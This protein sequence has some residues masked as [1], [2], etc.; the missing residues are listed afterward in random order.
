VPTRL[1]RA[2]AATAVSIGLLFAAAP[3]LPAMAAGSQVT[4]S[5]SLNV[6]SAPDAASQIVG[7]LYRGQTVEAVSEAGGWT[8]IRYP[9]VS[10]AYVFT[11]YLGT[12]AGLPTAGEV[13][14]GATRI[15]TTNV[16]LRKGAGL[17]YEVIT[18]LK[19]GLQVTL[20]GKTARGFSEVVNAS[21]TGWVSTQYLTDS[22]SGL[23]AVI[24]TRVA[25]ADL[26]VR[27]TSG[28]DAKTV[29]EVQQGTSLGVTGATANGR[30]QIVYNNAI[31]WVTARYL[32]NP[33]T[34]LPAP[35][36]LPEVTGT[37]YATA[38]LDIRSSSADSSTKIGEVSRGTQL[39]ITGVVQNA[40]MQ[41]VYDNAVR[42]VAAK[43]LSTSAPASSTP[44]SAAVENGL[45]P[46]AVKTY[47]AALAMFPQI[48]TV[49][50]VRPDTIPDHPSGRALDLMIP[51]YTSEAGRQLGGEVAAW[52]RANAASLGINYVIW[53]QQIW[54]IARDSDGWR[55]MASRGNDS[56]NHKNHVHITV[57]PAVS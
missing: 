38:T 13:S 46:N 23:P 55:Y 10:S 17:S 15:T 4:A 56:A 2:C 19:E 39:S 30:A 8:E 24:G 31:R 26:A 57:Y 53:D 22:A 20:T 7:G 18:V 54:N 11:A 33:A 16:N 43:Y 28:T 51:D 6:R 1:N 48:T 41:I 9:G 42:W 5:E 45:T 52:A 25:T 32:A 34:N 27:T 21:S 40:Q 36:T 14:A 3:A 37:R 49:Y 50:G 29:A 12:G 44:G 35:P 47:R